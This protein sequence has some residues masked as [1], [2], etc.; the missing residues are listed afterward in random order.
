[1]RYSVTELEA[2]AIVESVKHFIS[3]L[4]GQP[5][6][7]ITNHRP[8]TSLLLSKTLNHCL[9]GK[10]NKLIKNNMKIIYR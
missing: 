6:T 7:I 2:L 5:F 9:H 1:M 8:P 3:Y 4:Y 10:A